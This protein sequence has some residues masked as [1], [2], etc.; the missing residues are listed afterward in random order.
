VLDDR[1]FEVVSL[2]LNPA[3]LAALMP[4]LESIADDVPVFVT[5]SVDF[6]AITGVNLHRGSLALVRRPPARTVDDLLP[7]AQTAVVLE[8]VTDADNVGAVFRNA[9][10]F[11][12]DAV[13][14]SPTCCDPLYRKAIRTSM[15]ATLR[16][17]FA[18]VEPWV[19]G[20][21]DFQAHGFTLVA[22]TP[23]APAIPL[24]AFAT[25]RPAGKLALIV[26][27]EGRGLSEEV[28]QFADVRVRIPMRSDVDSLNLAVASGIALERLT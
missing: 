18:R 10:A 25:A 6:L 8:G 11:G 22:L 28:E 15:G 14:A 17:P 9:A 26:G 3:S 20:L 24:D 7:H 27:T 4:A 5:G 1:S 13:F 21:R 12:V 2:L 23:R 19:D 16:V